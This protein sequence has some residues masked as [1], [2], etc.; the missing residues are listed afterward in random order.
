[1]IMKVGHYYRKTYKDKTYVIVKCLEPFDYE[2][3]THL[4][5]ILFD[6][7]NFYPINK[8]IHICIENGII[9][10]ISKDTVT[11]ELI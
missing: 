11:L 7:M 5:L 4:C 2:S 1:M 8:K 6:S 10:E 3:S 9:E